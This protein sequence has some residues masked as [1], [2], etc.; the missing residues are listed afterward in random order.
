LSKGRPQTVGRSAEQGFSLIE[1]LV[2][3]LVIAAL[4]AIAIPQFLAQGGKARDASAKELVHH[5]QVAAEAIATGD[6]GSYENVTA[7]EIGKIEP[8]IPVAK[9]A[10]SAYISATT[11]GAQEYSIT[12]T[13]TD[14]DEMTLAR[15]ASGAITRTCRSPVVK[16]GCA[17]GE[18]G[19]W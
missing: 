12:A 11:H 7:E 6:D 8:N 19:S 9:T 15:S 1:L 14:G 3:C 16:N 5:A 18:T 2:V 17:E 10:G 13:S 4:C